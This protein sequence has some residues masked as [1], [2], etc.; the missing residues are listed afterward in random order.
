[1][2]ASI[3]PSHV[4]GVVDVFSALS[5]EEQVALGGL[6]RRLGKGG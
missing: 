5:P 4:A 1:M 2:I 3:L 6:L